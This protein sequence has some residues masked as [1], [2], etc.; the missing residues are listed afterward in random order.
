MKTRYFKYIGSPQM[1]RGEFGVTVTGGHTTN[2]DPELISVF[3]P[4]FG[5]MG[6]I[7]VEAGLAEGDWVEISK[8]QHDAL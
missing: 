1:T 4:D 6:W 8:A 2:E 7:G 5:D 3:D